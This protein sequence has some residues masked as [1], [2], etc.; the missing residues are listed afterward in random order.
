[1][2]RALSHYVELA[3]NDDMATFLS[4]GFSPL[5]VARVPPQPLGPASIRRIDQ[6]NTGQLLVKI[7]PVPKSWSYEVRYA[8]LGTGGTPGLWTSQP[9][10]AIASP[11]ACNGLNPGTTYAFQ[12][13][14]LGRLGFSDWSDSVTKM[15][16]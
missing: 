11:T 15:C 14:T 9:I 10:T 8:A 6:G 2:L 1:M 4:S 13:R 12:V 7:V 3:A 5:A 16:T